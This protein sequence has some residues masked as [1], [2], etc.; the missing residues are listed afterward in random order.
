MLEVKPNYKSRRF[1]MMTLVDLFLSSGQPNDIELARSE[2][3][4][5]RDEHDKIR[6]NYW[7]WRLNK[8]P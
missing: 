6:N 3:I 1:V 7:Q 4:S 2:M 5:L 8:L